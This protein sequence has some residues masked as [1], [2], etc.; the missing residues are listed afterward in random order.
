M[1]DRKIVWMVL[2]IAMCGS[3]A[4]AERILLN[5]GEVLIGPITRRSE[6][7]ITVAHPFLGVLAIPAEKIE[8]IY[9]DD[10][11]IP[12]EQAATA[13]AP[14]APAEAAPAPDAPVIPPAPAGFFDGW[15][16]NLT[17]G[18]NGSSG[19][20]ESINLHAAFSSKK[21]TDTDRWV[22]DASTFYGA[23]EGN[24]TQNEFTTGLL[25]DWL[26]PDSKWF[27]YAAGRYDYD[28][29]QSWSHRFSS[30]GGVGY[31]WFKQE[32]LELLSRAGMNA[33]YEIGSEEEGIVPEALL[34]SELMW[35]FLPDHKL[36]ASSYFFPALDELGE[37]RMENKIDWSWLISKEHKLS[38][39]FGIKHEHESDTDP[40]VKQN[41]VKYYGA[42]SVEF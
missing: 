5:S 15:D 23:S 36:T 42:L 37:F 14:A 24:K 12:A 1:C 6:S 41:D 2:L 32:K 9:A 3:T 20:V 17:L 35:K 27:Y 13:A 38:L 31:Q 29:F 39:K 30:G 26:I 18:F 25:K 33:T 22:F 10:E 21:E 11:P 28:E 7:N 8:G 40:G 34:G 19:N 16:S 4:R